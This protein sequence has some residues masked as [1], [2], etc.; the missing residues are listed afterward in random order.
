[1]VVG[2]GLVVVDGVTGDDTEGDDD[3]NGRT[4]AGGSDDKI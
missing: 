1:M 2:V 3:L 4:E